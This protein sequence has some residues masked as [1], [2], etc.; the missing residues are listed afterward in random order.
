[1]RANVKIIIIN[2]INKRDLFLKVSFF[3]RFI[4]NMTVLGAFLTNKKNRISSF[5]LM[6]LKKG[7]IFSP[8][9][10]NPNRSDYPTKPKSYVS[11]NNNILILL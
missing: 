10:T 8:E 7:L 9:Q 1:M 6:R 11:F 2:C 5:E 4:L 3:D